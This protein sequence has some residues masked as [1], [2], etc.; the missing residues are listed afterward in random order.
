ME[1][2]SCDLSTAAPPAEM[3][4]KHFGFVFVQWE[5][6]QT[7]AIFMY[8]HWCVCVNHLCVCCHVVCVSQVE[9]EAV[10]RAIT[11]AKQANCPLYVTKV[12]S[13]SA[14]DVIAKA[15]KKGDIIILTCSSSCP[16]LGIRFR[17]NYEGWFWFT[18]S[19]LDTGGSEGFLRQLDGLSWRSGRRLSRRS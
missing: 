14:A 11:I 15:R 19:V 16:F 2:S 4:Q 3:A 9:T 8:S 5:E 18:C 17:L 13:K 6:M 7:A 1:S 10:Y 12:M